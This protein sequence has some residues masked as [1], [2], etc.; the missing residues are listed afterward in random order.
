MAHASIN[1]FVHSAVE[2]FQATK[3]GS[4]QNSFLKVL[5]AS[6]IDFW[7]QCA[8]SNT[9]IF[10]QFSINIL[11]F[12]TKEFIHN[13]IARFNF[14]SQSRVGEYILFL[15]VFFFV[16][17]QIN[18]QFLS[19]IGKLEIQFSVISLNASSSLISSFADIRCLLFIF[20]K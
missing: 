6:I 16:K 20:H 12:S 9:K 13:A 8:V 18:I 19:T 11:V 4:F 3:I 5:T 10:T 15:I 17:I 14:Q 2:T 7:Y 1:A